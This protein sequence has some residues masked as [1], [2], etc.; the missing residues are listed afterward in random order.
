VAAEA[1]K[2]GCQVFGG[3]SPCVRWLIGPAH[4]FEW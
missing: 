4:P 3:D 2:S 1:Q